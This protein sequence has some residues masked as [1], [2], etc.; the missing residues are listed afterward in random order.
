[1][2]Q[3]KS[4][5]VVLPAYNEAAVVA[6]TV[7]EAVQWLTGRVGDF[8]VIV[9]D[10]GSTDGTAAVV[11]DAMRLQPA[12][13]LV[14][15]ERNRGYGEALRSGFEAARCEWIF[16]TDA[17]GQFDVGEL[18]DF[19]PLTAQCDFVTGY[20][21][22]RADPRRRAAL[23]WGYNFLVRA[24]FG[25]RVRDVG[26]AFKLFRRD[27]WQR[28]GPA[29]RARDHK[30]FSVEWVWRVQRSGTR[31]CE[32]PVRHRTRRAGRATGARPDVVWAMLR[33]LVRLRWRG[34]RS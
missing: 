15:H 14:C 13:R 23:T 4:L 11:R 18:A 5:S 30:I 1:M 24:L 33:E 28:V 6:E 21:A 7:G 9:V 34:L 26:C 32:R 25:L 17:D 8:E 31:L 16:L 12:V 2:M 22:N 3:V 19:F 29:V 20:R 27:S 10:D